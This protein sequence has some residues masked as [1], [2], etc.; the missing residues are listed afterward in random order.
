[1]KNWPAIA[2]AMNL[3]IPNEQLA[4]IATPLDGLETAFAPL[5]GGIASG[6]DPASIFRAAVE[7]AE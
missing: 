3:D 6:T 1:M 4:R 2:H 5:R 7:E